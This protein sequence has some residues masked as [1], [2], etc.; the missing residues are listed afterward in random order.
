[1]DA[2]KPFNTRILI[3]IGM[4]LLLLLV[5]GL[6]LLSR[7]PKPLPPVTTAQPTTFPERMV[8]AAVFGREDVPTTFP[9]ANSPD[10]LMG[11]DQITVKRP[12]S[13]AASR[14][15]LA[16]GERVVLKP[17]GSGQTPTESL[18]ITTE[19]GTTNTL[20]ASHTS[21]YEKLGYSKA[22]RQIQGNDSIE[23]R[24]ILPLAESK[25]LK[26]PDLLQNIVIFV[27]TPGKLYTIT[28]HYIAAEQND[29]IESSLEDIV[30]TIQFK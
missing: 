25:D 19:L 30:S 22:T 13:W 28:Y 5:I 21:L 29:E 6:F 20:L 26:H 3:P 23:Y 12:S 15:A 7:V 18:S 27:P 24:G 10:V 14:D 2:A 1:M 16:N 11:T 4:G 17:Q 8:T 9:Q